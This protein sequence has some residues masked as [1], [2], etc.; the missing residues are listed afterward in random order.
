MARPHLVSRLLGVGL[1]GSAAAFA[2]NDSVPAADPAGLHWP[3]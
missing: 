3:D 1:L 2:A